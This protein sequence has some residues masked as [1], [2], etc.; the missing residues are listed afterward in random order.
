MAA[1]YSRLIGRNGIPL[2]RNL[3][4]QAVRID[5]TSYPTGGQSF[6]PALV[7]LSK[8]FSVQAIPSEPTTAANRDS[9]LEW[10][11]TNNKLFAIVASTGAEVANTVDLGTYDLLIVGR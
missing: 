6:T 3:R 5:I 10:D 2:A 7:G 11:K 9:C 8:I 1:T 4:V